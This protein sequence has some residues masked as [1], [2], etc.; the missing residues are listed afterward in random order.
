MC[1]HVYHT[2][3]HLVACYVA[4][5]TAVHFALETMSTWFVSINSII[6]NHVISFPKPQTSYLFVCY[7]TV[8]VMSACVA[9]TVGC[10]CAAMAGCLL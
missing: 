8:V 1:V 3:I 2:S 10:Q 6:D 9:L 7:A 5:T 4:T